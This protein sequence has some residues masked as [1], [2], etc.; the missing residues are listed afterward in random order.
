MKYVIVVECENG[1]TCGGRTY[2]PEDLEWIDTQF[3]MI[4]KM[5]QQEAERNPRYHPSKARSLKFIRLED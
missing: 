3:H 4:D 1:I 5:D 2:T